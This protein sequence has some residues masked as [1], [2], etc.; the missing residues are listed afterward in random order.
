VRVAS[1]H[2]ACRPLLLAVL[3]YALGAAPAAAATTCQYLADRTL[4]VSLPQPGDVAEVVRSGDNIFVSAAGAPVACVGGQPTV[5]NT[6]TINLEDFA[7]G[8]NQFTVDLSGGPLAPGFTPEL[9]SSDE[10]EMHVDMFFGDAPDQLR[11]RGGTGDESLRLGLQ[12]DHTDIN[13]NAGSEPGTALGA[14]VD[15]TYAA[16]DETVVELGDGDDRI[17]ASDGAE[18]QGPFAADLTL[19]GQAG[20]DVLVEVPEPM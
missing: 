1:A 3:L 8:S 17:D 7:P 14:D 9:G 4:V 15:L 11:V 5:R 12:S 6:D 13:L 10:I 18:F 19:D 20:A 2:A 16:P